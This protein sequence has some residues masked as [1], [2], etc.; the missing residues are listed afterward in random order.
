MNIEL[1]LINDRI[2]S[3]DTLSYGSIKQTDKCLDTLGH[4]DGQT[5]GFYECH[6]QGGNQVHHIT[7]INVLNP[8]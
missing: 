2:P 7:S 3:D 5:I 1:Y 8:T 6:G 4:S